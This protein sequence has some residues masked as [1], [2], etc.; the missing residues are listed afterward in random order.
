MREENDTSKTVQILLTAREQE[1][2][3][4]LLKG[5]APKKIGHKLKIS[6]HTVLGHQKNLYRKLSV[7]SIN[8]L[9][10][11]YSKPLAGDSDVFMDWWA[12]NNNLKVSITPDREYIENKYFQ[13]F[14]ISGTY[15]VSPEHDGYCGAVFNP[16]PSIHGVIRKMTSFS[17]TYLGDGNTYSVSFLSMQEGDTS[18]YQK[19]AFTTKKGETS[20][21]TINIEELYHESAPFNQNNIDFILLEVHKTNKFNL[22]I[23]NFRFYL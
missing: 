5:D 13:T 7:N 2:F 9:L 23:W 22:K 14:T 12:Y 6:Y 18:L 17:F 4:L 15:F 11:K 21:L 1:V 8:E 20:T 19:K 3:D 10:I 16:H